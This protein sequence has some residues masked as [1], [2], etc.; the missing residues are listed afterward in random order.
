MFDRRNAILKTIINHFIETAEPVGSQTIVVSYH[1]DVS[2]ATIRNDM[3]QLEHEGYLHQPHT[4]A[5]RVPTE[6]GYRLYVDSMA[7][8]DAATKEAQRELTKLLKV[9]EVKKARER[10]YDAVWLL[11]QGTDLVSFATIP[12]NRRTFYLG[13]SNVLKQPEFMKDPMQASQVV[14]ALENNDRFVTTLAQL[15]LGEHEVKIFIGRENLLKQI[16]S[17]SLIV[18]QYNFQGFR[19][20]LGLLGPMRTRF[21][22]NRAM[23]E[24]VKEL[25]EQA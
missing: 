24:K 19:G 9:Y 11:S 21:A 10:I 5:G 15:P 23:V 3:M 16:R 8:Y 25:V 20:F 22:F 17:C 4:S 6:Q 13:V 18:G 12:D 7:D 14:E 2:P 1:F